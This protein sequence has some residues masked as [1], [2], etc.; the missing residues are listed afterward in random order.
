IDT[1]GEFTTGCTVTDFIGVSGRTPNTDVLL[2]IDR[3][4]LVNMVIDAVNKYD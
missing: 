4:K 3:E 1:C 2:G